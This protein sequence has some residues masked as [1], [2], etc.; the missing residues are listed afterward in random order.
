MRKT[1]EILRQK[2]VLN[3]TH[4]EVT[5]SLGVSI[6]AVSCAV[7]RALTAGLDWPAVEALSETEL[8]DRL[9][10]RRAVAPQPT[11]PDCDYLH[12]ER[13]KPGTLIDTDLCCI[14]KAIEMRITAEHH[15]L[16][17][18]LRALANPNRL[19]IFERIHDDGLCCRTDRRGNTV[20]AIARDFEL[21]L[22]TVSHHLKELRSAG[23]ITC[24]RRGQQVICAINHETLARVLELLGRQRRGG[25]QRRAPAAGAS[26]RH[27]GAEGEEYGMRFLFVIDPLDT[28][29]LTTETSL[30]L[31]EEMARRGH[32]AAVATLPDLYLDE[33]GAGVRARSIALDLTRRPFYELGGPAELRFGAFDLILMRKD[34]PVDA[35]YIIATFVLEQAA[36]EAPVVNDPVSL[37]SVNEK[38]LP[39]SLP[40][41]SPPTL[42]S[43]DAGR[44]AAFAAAHGRIVLK[45][46]Q[47]CSGRGIEVFDRSRAQAVIGPYLA[48]R[49]GS[50]VMAQRFLPGVAA[51]DK[52]ILL[53]GG[54][55]LGVVNR[56]PR[57]PDHLANIHQGARVEA[58]DLTPRDR[59]I[60]A[61][62]KPLL[63]ERRLWLAGID[64]IDGHLT[65]I[66]VTSPSAARQINAVSGTHI[67]VPIVDFLER[68][69]ASALS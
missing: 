36:A 48:A 27:G 32:E 33:R 6:G 3:L 46:L 45:P 37:R 22:S 52:R 2:W 21:A 24:E 31:I 66:N 12:R 50:Y 44:L 29:N 41:F 51:G 26:G 57:S 8:E 53:L 1:Q 19:A 5:A 15:T 61:A 54:E 39:L 18:A 62:V 23:L 14:S 35:D 11:P 20:C 63:L 10:A 47:D 34:P 49:G 4:R 64:V 30:L 25:R 58:T 67:E 17:R 69:A 28:L 60:I 42:I 7:H 55:P 43:N 38:L 9:Y 68:L 16:C 56:L 13:H 59:E 40:Q 65:E